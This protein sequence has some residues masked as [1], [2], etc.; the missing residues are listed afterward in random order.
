MNIWSTANKEDRF[1][2][3]KSGEQSEKHEAS[4]TNGIEIPC[5]WSNSCADPDRTS[6]WAS[7]RPAGTW[8]GKITYENP[9]SN[10]PSISCLCIGSAATGRSVVTIDIFG[11]ILALDARRVCWGSFC[12]GNPWYLPDSFLLPYIL[13]DST[14][15]MLVIKARRVINLLIARETPAWWDCVILRTPSE[16]SNHVTNTSDLQENSSTPDVYGKRRLD[17]LR[18]HQRCLP[19]LVAFGVD[20]KSVFLPNCISEIGEDREHFRRFLVPG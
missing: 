15:Y 8:F 6:K 12:G 3:K 4:N 5:C 17:N 13:K 1:L 10:L 19:F 9:L 20:L 18:L 16:F 14:L 7:K 2:H 11:V